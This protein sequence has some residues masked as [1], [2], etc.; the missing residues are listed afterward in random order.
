M[1]VRRAATAR[2]IVSAAKVIRCIQ[3]SLVV[4]VVVVVVVTIS[5]N[6]SCTD[7]NECDTNNGGC[8]HSCHNVI[9]SF[10]CTCAAGHRLAE[11]RRACQRTCLS[12]Y[13]LMIDVYT[14]R[15]VKNFSEFHIS[16][17][18]NVYIVLLYL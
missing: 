10:M 14:L 5:V 9:G 4:V 6:Y 12:V 15:S 7:V 1:S 18:R 13:V 8:E 16:S 3:Y 11:D 2:R 17:R